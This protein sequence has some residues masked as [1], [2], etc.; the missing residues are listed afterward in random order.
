[1]QKVILVN[2][3]DEQLT[4]QFSANFYDALKRIT[5]Q[6][7]LFGVARPLVDTSCRALPAITKAQHIHRILDLFQEH[8]SLLKSRKALTHTHTHIKGKVL[9]LESFTGRLEWIGPNLHTFGGGN[10]ALMQIFH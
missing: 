7:Q 3:M 6:Y 4:V 8:C 2:K 10:I 5:L 9:Q 1:M